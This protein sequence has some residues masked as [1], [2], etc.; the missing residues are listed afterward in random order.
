M[1]HI[2]SLFHYLSEKFE[3]SVILNV[4]PGTNQ[5]FGCF[6]RSKLKRTRSE[7]WKKLI[8]SLFQEQCCF[9]PNKSKLIRDGDQ[10]QEKDKKFQIRFI[11]L[12]MEFCY[13]ALWFLLTFSFLLLTSY[14]LIYLAF[15]YFKNFNNSLCF[16]LLPKAVSFVF[17]LWSIPC[18]HC[19]WGY[20]FELCTL[21]VCIIFQ[22]MIF[23]FLNT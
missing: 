11:H 15:K 23:C 4:P 6:H 20:T 18:N 2:T 1:P 17:L 21:Q 14:F 5:F 10:Q 13:T 22:A 19:H 3:I 16:N 8:C 9:W 7:Y 12:W